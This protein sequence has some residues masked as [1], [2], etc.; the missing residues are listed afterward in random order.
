[1]GSD[2]KSL[3]DW[4]KSRENGQIEKFWRAIREKKMANEDYDFS[5]YTFPDFEKF[6]YSNDVVK[7]D[8][9]KGEMYYTTKKTL[10]FW[11]K[12]TEQEMV[13]SQMISFRKAIFLGWADFRCITFNE[14]ASFKYATFTQKADFGWVNF[15]ERADFERTRFQGETSFWETGFLSITNFDWARFSKQDQTIFEHTAFIECQYDPKSPSVTFK[16]I[17]FPALVTFRRSD[18]SRASFTDSNI[19][20]VHF[21][22][23]DF[24]CLRVNPNKHNKD[25][26]FVKSEPRKILWDAKCIS[27]SFA[28]VSNRIW[29]TIVFW[30]QTEMV[31]AKQFENVETRYRQ[32]K[33]NFE[34]K[35][36]WESAGDFYHGEMLMRLMKYRSERAEKS[37]QAYW[38][39]PRWICYRLFLNRGKTFF[40]RWY[41]W[42][43][44]F[45][46]SPVRALGWLVATVGLLSVVFLFLLRSQLGTFEWEKAFSFAFTGATP[47]YS[48]TQQEESMLSAANGMTI[49][50]VYY[51][52]VFLSTIVWALL[53]L[54]IRQKFKR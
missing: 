10:N 51:A 12:E 36:D 38:W 13:F 17:V 49:K 33:K 8:R 35:R 7:P 20:E 34:E 41:L 26:P 1:M 4:T 29:Q 30:K 22:E 39:D 21:D 23:C 27:P 32:F 42:I 52:E 9:S 31:E 45:N 40:L 3:R 6:A 48:L 18:L 44:D 53:I 16:D 50:W 24:G 5:K 11:K 28:S 14:E 43:S 46:E 37:Q 2:G 54:S 47:L 19:E 25:C 15:L